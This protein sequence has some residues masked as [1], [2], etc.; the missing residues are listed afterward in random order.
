M[1]T[2][3]YCCGRRAERAVEAEGKEEVTLSDQEPTPDP[4]A[5]RVSMVCRHA[6]SAP[7]PSPHCV[8][9]PERGPNGMQGSAGAV[10]SS[11][12]TRQATAAVGNLAARAM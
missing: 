2:D 1:D 8:L 4:T 3:N 9:L 5:V 11:P 6:F 7:V 10:N 12:K